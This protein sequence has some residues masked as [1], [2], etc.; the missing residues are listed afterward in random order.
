MYTKANH[1]NSQSHQHNMCNYWSFFVERRMFNGR[2]KTRYT[3][4]TELCHWE[5]VKIY[6]S[7]AINAFS[8]I[9]HSYRGFGPIYSHLSEEFA[10]I[11]C[12]ARLGGQKQDVKARNG[13]KN[14][15]QYR[16]CVI[17]VLH[18]TCVIWI[19]LAAL[20]LP[21]VWRN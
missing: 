10:E 12:V 16:K 4:V 21:S 1:L 5:Y 2:Y 20:K 13:R 17:F 6:F 8:C 18:G 7:T 19:S 14:F 3:V 9:V 15:Q 11:A